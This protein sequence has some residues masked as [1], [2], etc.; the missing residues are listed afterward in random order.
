MSD[1]T[2]VGWD[3]SLEAD[4]ALEWAVRRAEQA[5]DGVILVDV[6]DTS[7]PVPGEVITA[8]M[9]AARHRSA[10]EEAQRLADRYPGLRVS[11]HIMAGDRL[12]QLRSFSR[13]DNLV[14][15]GTGQRSGP[16]SR[17]GWSLGARLAATA[18]GAVA[19]VPGMPEPNRSTVVVGVD[20]SETSMKA[21]RFAAREARRLGHELLVVHAWLDPMAT[22]SDLRAEGSLLEAMEVEHRR[23]LDSAVETLADAN[24]DIVVS[25]LLVRDQVY[26]ALAAPARTASLLVVGSRQER[27]IARVLLGSVS[28]TMILHIEAPTIIVTPGCQI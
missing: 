10:D 4:V 16:R 15:V 23:M 28:H 9:V 17:Y 22:V 3:G 8:E 2:V 5:H 13:P 18:H 6:E 14:V 24:P 20:G 26:Y 11:T 27:G 21:A 1:R 12:E 7:R 19:V 25:E